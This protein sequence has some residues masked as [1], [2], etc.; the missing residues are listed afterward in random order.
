M[1]RFTATW[2]AK[3]QIAPTVYEI[4][5]ETSDSL[6]GYIP[7]QYIN[8]DFGERQYR[9]YSIAKL[10]TIENRTI[11]TLIVDVLT[12]GLASGYFSSKQPPQRL[13]CIGPVGRFTLSPS[14][15]KKV[16]IATNTGIA[17]M[18]A[19]ISQLRDKDPTEVQIIF[20]VKSIEYNYL[21]KYLHDIKNVI[22]ISNDKNINTGQF[23]G[24]VTDYYKLHAK[25]YNDC[26]FY[27]CGNPNMVSDI[28]GLLQTNGI[29][30]SCIFTEKFLLAKK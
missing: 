25:E 9:S 23:A 4:I 8:I 14:T 1:S 2:T 11:L 16:F 13:D 19:M 24:R 12:N 6:L 5:L 18:I 17:P 15:R 28:K 21:S 27:L 10:E 26:D 20:G 7:G 29:E 30:E 22:C 3:T